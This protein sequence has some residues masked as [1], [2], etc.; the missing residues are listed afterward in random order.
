MRHEP[1]PMPTRMFPMFIT[2]LLVVLLSIALSGCDLT[3][4]AGGTILTPSSGSS[5]T[6][7]TGSGATASP[8]ADTST[9]GSPSTGS[10][11]TPTPAP[12][13][14]TSCSQVSGFAS[15]GSISAGSHFSDVSF[16]ANTIGF[17]AQKFETS[18]YQFEIINACTKST[19]VSTI[20]TYYSS[21]LPTTGFVQTSTFPYHGNA[22][23]ACGDPYCWYKDGSHPSFQARRYVS[24]ESVTAHGSVVSYSLRLSIAPILRTGVVIQ[25]TYEYDFDLV[26]NPDVQWAQVTSTIRKMTPENGATIANIGVTNFTNVTLAQVKSKSFSTSAL[27]GND[28]SSNVLVNGDVWAVHTDLGSYVKV[29]VTSYGY[30]ITLTYVWYEYSF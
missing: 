24:L 12:V 16:H 1:T 11:S 8:T 25:G 29:V 20:H 18:N 28:D 27:D 6:S 10:S 14:I 30:N 4:S 23:S 7:T 17:I 19:S 5:Q 13:P 21:G 3:G 9:S 15:A 2:L 26:S 22:S